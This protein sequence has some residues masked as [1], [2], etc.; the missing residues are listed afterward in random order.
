MI[1]PAAFA[2]AA[3]A[4]SLAFAP[5]A[6]LAQTGAS[7]VAEAAAPVTEADVEAQA[8]IFETAIEAMTE[9]M[10]AAIKTAGGAAAAK[11]QLDAIQ[12][13]Y[14]LDADAFA[15]TLDKFVDAQL[16][17]L[18]AEARAS[19]EAV[20]SAVSVVRGA[21]AMARQ[22]IEAAGSVPAED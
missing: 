1:R 3:F 22:Q 2:S 5:V 17:V 21:P 18:P 6:A 16:T 7:P 15:N 4:V 11:P 20:R 14:Q 10:E 19:M 9:E 13:K 12:A 8:E